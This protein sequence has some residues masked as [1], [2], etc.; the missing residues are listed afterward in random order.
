MLITLNFDLSLIFGGF[1]SRDSRIAPV[2]INAL[3]FDVSFTFVSFLTL[4]SSLLLLLI[5]LLLL[6]STI[7]FPFSLKL[8]NVFCDNFLL[9]NGINRDSG[10]L[11]SR[12]GERNPDVVITT[13]EISLSLRSLSVVSDFYHFALIPDFYDSK[14][15]RMIILLTHKK[16]T[17]L[18]RIHCRKMFMNINGSGHNF[19]ASW[20]HDQHLYHE[21]P[22]LHHQYLVLLSGQSFPDKLVGHDEAL[23]L[24]SKRLFVIN[25]RFAVN[26]RDIADRAIVSTL[27]VMSSLK[28][29]EGDSKTALQQMIDRNCALLIYIGNGNDDLAKIFYDT[30]VIQL[31][32]NELFLCYKMDPLGPINNVNIPSIYLLEKNNSHQYIINKNQVLT[33][34]NDIQL[35]LK[36]Q[37]LNA[38][39]CIIKDI[40]DSINVDDNKQKYLQYLTDITNK[41][42]VFDSPNINSGVE[43]VAEEIKKSNDIAKIKFKVPCKDFMI[44]KE[45]QTSALLKDIATYILNEVHL[46]G[47]HIKLIAHRQ[48]TDEDFDQTLDALN[49]CPSSTIYVH[50][51]TKQSNQWLYSILNY[52][53]WLGNLVNFTI[54]TPFNFIQDFLISFARPS[55]SVE[56]PRTINHQNKNKT[57]TV[58]KNS[59]STIKSNQLVVVGVHHQL[60]TQAW[61]DIKDGNLVYIDHYSTIESTLLS[62]FV[63]GHVKKSSELKQLDNPDISDIKS[64]SL[65]SLKDYAIAYEHDVSQQE[66]RYHLISYL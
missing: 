60:K 11:P 59:M 17:R 46:S 26:R 54:I 51:D 20:F 64:L 25:K 44:V 24:C 42:R 63:S 18:F 31:L 34:P 19:S 10:N 48:F 38:I 7:F 66:F 2:F 14:M 47:R 9:R 56:A 30:N 22:F 15:Y 40:S 23:V 52:Q 16:F 27:T 28:W 4:E 39:Q 57:K 8:F 41:L 43:N 61:H 37:L 45:F 29:F 50:M 49:L 1:L 13:L 58:N 12:D 21:M 62:Q 3:S 5:I 35:D 55:P 33:N 65:K 53:S 36:S 6:L 32:N